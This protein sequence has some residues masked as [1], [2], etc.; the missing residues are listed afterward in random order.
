MKSRDFCYWLQGYFEI[1]GDS[2]ELSEAQVDTIRR[3][4]NMVFIHEID[5]SFPADQ[6]DALSDAHDRVVFD[7]ETTPPPN[8]LPGGCLGAASM[9]STSQAI[10]KC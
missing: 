10:M 8:L 1:S 7:I 6:Q 4:L 2:F 3:H 5:P 9:D